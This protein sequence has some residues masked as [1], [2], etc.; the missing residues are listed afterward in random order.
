MP[1]PRFA[2]QKNRKKYAQPSDLDAT[3]ANYIDQTT[4][5][6]CLGRLFS[7]PSRLFNSN[8]EPLLNALCRRGECFFKFLEIPFPFLRRKEVR[9]KLNR[10]IFGEL[11]DRENFLPIRLQTIVDQIAKTARPATSRSQWRRFCRYC[12]KRYHHEFLRDVTKLNNAFA[13][14]DPDADALYEP[15]LSP[16][17]R[18]QERDRFFQGI[19]A[20]LRH[21][22]FVELPQDEIQKS[23]RLS[24]P[25]SLPIIARL[26]CFEEAHVFIRGAVPLEPIVYPRWQGYGRFVAVETELLSRVCVLARVKV[27]DQNGVEKDKL[28]F[29]L[30]KNVM[31]E[32]LKMAIPNV[33]FNFPY[34]KAFTAIVAISVVIGSA[35]FWGAST[36]QWTLEA[37]AP[38]LTEIA[39]HIPQGARDFCSQIDWAKTFAIVSTAFSLICVTCAKILSFIHRRNQYQ[40]RYS[41]ALYFQTLAS[42]RAA[43]SLLVSLAEEQEVKEI[44]LGYFAVSQFATWTSEKTIDKVAETWLADKFKLDV[45]FESDDAIRKLLEKRLVESRVNE[46]GTLEY[47]AV[48]LDEAIRRLREDWRA[49]EEEEDAADATEPLVA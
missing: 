42:N 14:F 44:V 5:T 12:V 49:L 20:L 6:G 2:P 24:R 26:D 19:C 9:F 28:F 38:Q 13:P 30:F 21:G 7:L 29:K 33:R 16:E 47:R 31:L 23:L 15:P 45:D 37:Y 43:I 46:D 18:Q 27:K 10:E 40:K 34:F 11:D 36:V 1:K 17:E 48:S 41:S 25:G 4:P 35:V 22:N 39:K 8:L 32:E 3:I